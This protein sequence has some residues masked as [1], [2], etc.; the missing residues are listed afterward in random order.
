MFDDMQ[1]MMQRMQSLMD[2]SLGEAPLGRPFL[3]PSG[4]L[5]SRLTK[6]PIM[7]L[8]VVEKPEA[9]EVQAELPGVKKEDIKVEIHDNRVTISA[10]TASE[11]EKKEGERVIYSERTEGQVSRRFTLPLELDEARSGAKFDNGVL[12]LTLIKRA[13]TDGPRQLSVL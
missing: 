12:T 5:E 1:K 11:Q 6:T 8:H 13:G 10:R 4:S 7:A 3:L 2:N 9:Y